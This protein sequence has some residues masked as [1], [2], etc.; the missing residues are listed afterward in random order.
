[1]RIHGAR[2]WDA[3][4]CSRVDAKQKARCPSAAKHEQKS[5]SLLQCGTHWKW[6]LQGVLRQASARRVP[7]L[8]QHPQPALIGME[9]TA[10][11]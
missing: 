3:P 10:D 9:S 1:M 7:A 8:L 6:S 11:C 5:I 4:A 2:E